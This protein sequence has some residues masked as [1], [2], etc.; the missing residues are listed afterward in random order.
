MVR[1][2]MSFGTADAKIFVYS[3]IHI[4]PPRPAVVEGTLFED[5]PEGGKK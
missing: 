1:P 3:Q 2:P 5:V 4:P